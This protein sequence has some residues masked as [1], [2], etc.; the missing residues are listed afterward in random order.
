MHL[1]T[2]YR[3]FAIGYRRLAATLT[4]PADKQAMELFAAG[5]DRVAENRA[6][7]V[8]SKERAEP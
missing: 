5:W 4:E 7:I 1:V 6:A 3:Q 8:R 2:Q